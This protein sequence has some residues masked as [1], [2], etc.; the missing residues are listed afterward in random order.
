VRSDHDT[1]RFDTVIIG[2]GQ[3]GLAVGY[4]LKQRECPFVILDANE[5]IGDSW[6]KRW[7]SLRLFTPARYDGLPG[8]PFPAPGWSFPTREEMGDYLAAYAARF[9]LPVRT[10]VHVEQLSRDGDRYVVT[11][12]GRSFEANQVVVA[13]GAL[14]DPK[15]PRFASELDPRI[16]QF[17]SSEYKNPSQLQEGA[18]LLVGAGNSGAEIAYELSRTHHTL[19]AGR[20]VGKIPVRHGGVGARF[21]LP[22]FRFVGHHVLT[23]GTPVG[24][25]VGPKAAAH[26]P[27]IRVQPKDLAASGIERVPR[28]AGVQDGLPVLEDGRVLDVANV[29]WCTGFRQDFSWIDLPILRAD[30]QPEHRRGVASSEPGLYFAG[31]MFQYSLSSDVLPGIG[32]D[33]AYVAKAI[34]RRIASR[35]ASDR[36][37]T[38]AL[39][40]AVAS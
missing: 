14:R 23:R 35:A 3:A 6:R 16:V 30:G 13:S 28:V 15:L 27:L 31:L 37:E 2:G 33:A 19:L 38:P 22:V 21:F 11:A 1:E 40:K 9:E 17:H 24:R 8:M 18:V 7:D 20:D 26:T 12:G 4:Y 25:K 29:V 32:R 34:A 36:T 5:Q 10:G 39:A